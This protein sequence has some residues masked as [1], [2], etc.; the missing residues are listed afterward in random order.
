MIRTSRST[1]ASPVQSAGH[2]AVKSTPIMTDG[3]LE[4]DEPHFFYFVFNRELHFKRKVLLAD[5][6]RNIPMQGS[7]WI[8]LFER[9]PTKYHDAI[10]LNLVTGAE[11]MMQSL[12]RLEN[13][14]AIMRGRMAGSTDAGKVLILPYDHIVNL[15]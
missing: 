13:D 7:S 2:I 14:Y 3:M 15:A 12:L 1:S 11:I 4:P 10:A 6:P 9:I 8:A 5:S